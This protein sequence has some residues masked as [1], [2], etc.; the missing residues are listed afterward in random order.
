[1]TYKA[2]VEQQ[3]E[4]QTKIKELKLNL[5]GYTRCPACGIFMNGKERA[6]TLW[7]EKARYGKCPETKM[8]RDPEAGRRE[9]EAEAQHN[10]QD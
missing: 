10:W 9:R 3:Q 7:C 2:T 6:A 8:A 1:M 5:A 4:A